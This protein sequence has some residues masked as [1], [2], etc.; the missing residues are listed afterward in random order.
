MRSGF[1][2]VKL[3]NDPRRLETHKSLR[4]R[5]ISLQS[6]KKLAH[7]TDEINR[8]VYKS[9]SRFGEQ[10]D[11]PKSNVVAPSYPKSRV[12]ID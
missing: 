11:P 4:H 8:I 9:L 10:R 1:Y 12:G 2:F 7:Q 5:T 6:T 3:V